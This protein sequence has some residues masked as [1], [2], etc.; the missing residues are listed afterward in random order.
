MPSYKP[1]PRGRAVIAILLCVLFTAG[2]LRAFL[3]ADHMAITQSA[4]TANS[5]NWTKTAI[6][7]IQ[8]ANAVTDVGND[9]SHP[10]T[11]NVPSTPNGYNLNGCLPLALCAACQTTQPWRHFDDENILEGAQ[12]VLQLEQEFKTNALAGNYAEA[13][14][15]L[16]YALHTLQDFYAHS[17]WVDLGNRSI[18]SD[19]LTLVTVDTSGNATE[20]SSYGPPYSASHPGISS[21]G[22]KNVA[23]CQSDFATLLPQAASGTWTPAGA[24]SPAQTRILTTGYFLS[25]GTT[26]PAA[27]KCNHGVF[28]CTMGV[29]A[30]SK[31]GIAKDMTKHPLYPIAHDLALAHSQALIQQWIQDISSSSAALAGVYG[32]TP[33]TSVDA[34]GLT[35]VG[36]VNQGDT[37]QFQADPDNHHERI[38]WGREGLLG[39]GPEISCGP[40]GTPGVD[41]SDHSLWVT[42]RCRGRTSER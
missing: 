5:T 34:A 21:P 36:P 29:S 31:P 24:K 1:D 40:D 25:L 41:P 15:D 28:V 8:N 13:R 39:F 37:Y 38:V 35:R 11:P 2:R 23:V 6:T 33:P 17:N 22:V 7:E 4:L 14:K 42:R 20:T 9:P 30:T 32:R 16:G 27:G 12:W 3:V 26:M 18:F 19:L 10:D